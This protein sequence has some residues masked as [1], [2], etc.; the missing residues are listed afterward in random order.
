G[1][2][3]SAHRLRC[4]L[5]LGR[6]SGS[7]CAMTIGTVVGLQA[8]VDVT[9][10]LPNQQA[11]VAIG[12]VV[13]TGFEGALALPPDAVT[14]LGLPFYQEIFANL[15]DN[16][17]VKTDVHAATIIWNGAEIVVAVLAM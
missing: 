17:S 16:S 5:C 10:R 8:I 14:A 4:R 13:D 12:C 7:D 6:H 1:P 11:D 3:W 9:F 15:A 2:L